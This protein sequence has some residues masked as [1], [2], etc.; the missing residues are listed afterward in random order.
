MQKV[1]T[2]Y[3]IHQYDKKTAMMVSKNI[4]GTYPPSSIEMMREIEYTNYCLF[5]FAP[6]LWLINLLNLKTVFSTKKI[7]LDSKQGLSTLN[8]T[9]LKKVAYV[10]E[11]NQTVI[12][13]ANTLF[14]E[15]VAPSE[16]TMIK[17][18]IFNTIKEAK[19]WLK[20]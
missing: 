7:I 11:E 17:F 1:I 8:F 16:R 18:S 3:S 14:I 6:Q 15:M 10:I 20:G 13:F 19:V 4:S 9:K 12:D 2:D 5:K